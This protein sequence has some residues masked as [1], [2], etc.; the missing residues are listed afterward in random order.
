MRRDATRLREEICKALDELERLRGEKP[1]IAKA[2]DLADQLAV[3]TRHAH[4]FSDTIDKLSREHN[5]L[6][7]ALDRAIYDVQHGGC[8]KDYKNLLDFYMKHGERRASEDEEA[9]TP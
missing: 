6:R 2:E 4:R 5:V 8:D 7:E 1:E 3:M 9:K